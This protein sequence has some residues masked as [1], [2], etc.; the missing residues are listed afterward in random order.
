MSTD[1]KTGSKMTAGQ[2]SRLMTLVN[3]FMIKTKLIDIN[4]AVMKNSSVATV[5]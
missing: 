2:M 5:S 1:I 4:H 3:I